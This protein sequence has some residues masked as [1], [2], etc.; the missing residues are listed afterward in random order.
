MVVNSM[1]DDAEKLSTGSNIENRQASI[2]AN[3]S[4]IQVGGVGSPDPLLVASGG[5]RK[6]KPVDRGLYLV[7]P[8][9]R[10]KKTKPKNPKK[11]GADTEA[12]FE[13]VWICVECK[14]A[15]CMMEPDATDLLICDGLCRRLF[16][17]PCAGLERL[18][19]EEEEFIC[20]DCR[21]L[22]HTCAICSNYGKDDDEVF[23]CAKSDCGLFFHESC[24]AMRNVEVEI[25]I[26]EDSKKTTEKSLFPETEDTSST[27][28][29]RRFVCPAHSCWTCTQADLKERENDTSKAS[30]DTSKAKKGRGKKKTK[31]TSSF[32][33][34]SEKFMTVRLRRPVCI[35]DNL[36]HHHC[37]F[38]TAHH[39]LFFPTF[40]QRCLEC[41]I[42]YHISCIPPS[43]R[44]HELATLCHEHASTHKLPELDPE[45]SFQQ[46]IE[47]RIDKKFDDFVERR[48]RRAA[49][50]R[51]NTKNIFFRDMTGDKRTTREADLLEALR[52]D[53]DTEDYPFGF[54]GLS[55]CLPCD[56]KDEVHSKPPQYRHV[57]ALQYNSTNKPPRNPPSAGVCQCVDRCDDNCINRMLYTECYGDAT[58][59]GNGGKKQYNCLLGP[60]CGNRQL[61]QRQAAK[62]KPKREQGKGWGLCT[63]K[64]AKKGDLIQEYVGEVIDAATKE[65]R[66]IDWSK[67]HPN[68]PNFYIMALQPGWFID[69]RD[70]ANLSRFVNHSCEPNCALTQINVSGR[71]RCGIFAMRDIEAGEFLSYDYHFD[72]RHGDRFVCRCGSMVCRGTMKGGSGVNLDSAPKSKKE[73]WEEAK[74]GYERDK[75]FLAE[76]HEDREKRRTQVGALVPGADGGKDEFVANGLQAKH[77]DNVRS[78]RIFLWRNA[79][80]GND[81]AERFA[82][83]NSEE[84]PSS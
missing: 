39:H 74:A 72:T 5:K 76:F 50:A 35:L 77:R 75:K 2:G 24:L 36:L 26:D 30:S 41:P 66:L 60:N 49:A 23:K 32:E 15:E 3:D 78:N 47:K 40:L 82:R 18:P 12:E 22:K 70:V 20:E 68:D 43:A 37:G 29:K 67:E 33:S 80:Q 81:F 44:F 31:V 16:H 7:E 79:V 73:I 56:L 58:K 4:S 13:T 11:K 17:Y 46:S 45:A 14:E 8:E 10:L 38:L 21:N 83:L 69:A 6:R 51:A 64:P 57:H 42:A 25:V 65:Q 9:Q 55:F 27:A 52:K 53:D 71:M 62:C 1:E 48:N 63:V 84:Q 54:G 28:A 61:H 59:S 19:S 34:K